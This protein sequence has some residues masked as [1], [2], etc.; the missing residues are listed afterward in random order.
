VHTLLISPLFAASQLSKQTTC[1]YSPQFAKEC[2]RLQAPSRPPDAGL[3]DTRRWR[4]ADG[5]TVDDGRR[6]G[7]WRGVVNEA[8]GEGEDGCARHVLLLLNRFNEVYPK[9]PGLTTET[10]AER[11]LVHLLVVLAKTFVPPRRHGSREWDVY[12]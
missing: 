10:T 7:L 8:E 5:T 4:W 6:G 2:L 1:V 11:S 3:T 9:Y 12:R